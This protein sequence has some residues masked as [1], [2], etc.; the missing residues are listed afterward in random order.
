[1][2]ICVYLV[3]STGK[4]VNGKRG[5]WLEEYSQQ[6]VCLLLFVANFIVFLLLVV[7][8]IESFPWGRF[9]LQF[10]STCCVHVVFS[11]FFIL[12]PKKIYELKN[13]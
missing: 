12:F 3:G 13:L 8:V 1:M 2:R 4:S 6:N 5:H 10:Y 11:K 9:R 7:G